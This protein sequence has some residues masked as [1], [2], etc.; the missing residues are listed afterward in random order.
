M[1][2]KDRTLA[3]IV[4]ET[5]VVPESIASIGLSHSKSRNDAKSGIPY[6]N[7][8]DKASDRVEL[9]RPVGQDLAAANNV[10]FEEPW[11]YDGPRKSEY[12]LFASWVF[13][14]P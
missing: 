12:L 4:Q 9:V 3:V 8:I 10:E 11:M 6:F 2:K 1:K 13:P 14:S 7:R 5:T